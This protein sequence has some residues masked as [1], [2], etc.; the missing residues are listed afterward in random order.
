MTRTMNRREFLPL[1]GAGA[2]LSPTILMSCSNPTSPERISIPGT[3]AFQR[4]VSSSSDI[5]IMDWSA[6]TQINLTEDISGQHGRPF[7]GVD[8]STLYFDS[9][10]EGKR[11]IYR[12]DDV[13]DPAGSLQR[14]TD[15][16]GHQCQPIVH[17][18]G[19]LLVFNQKTNLTDY[20]GCLVAYDM[21][22]HQVV[23]MSDTLTGWVADD[24]KSEDKHFLPGESKVLFTAVAP[25]QGILNT[26][27]GDI[28]AYEFDSNTRNVTLHSFA[29]LPDGSYG[30]GN[31]VDQYGG[32]TFI[33][34]SC[35]EGMRNVETLDRRSWRDDKSRKMMS[36]IDYDTDGIIL[37][38][39]RLSTGTIQAKVQGNWKIGY[40]KLG[41]KDINE[42]AF[43]NMTGENYWPSFTT[44]E[45]F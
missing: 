34:W 29:L 22:T 7:W 3:I 5:Y 2:I 6:E 18:D 36:Y 9:E 15:E 4:V 40:I 43:D 26:E 30:Y 12:I 41:E 11:S 35:R 16:A 8:G 20:H 37:L 44:V 17:S 25:A 28:E 33:K 13:S 45:Y 21:D 14:I 39:R 38:S 1:A 19:K 27:T 24:D 23:S 10:V 42:A 31:G 32:E